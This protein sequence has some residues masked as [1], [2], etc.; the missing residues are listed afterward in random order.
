MLPLCGG[1]YSLKDKIKDNP[2]IEKTETLTP[3][4]AG[5]SKGYV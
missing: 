5:E 3:I 1:T 4:Q 2:I